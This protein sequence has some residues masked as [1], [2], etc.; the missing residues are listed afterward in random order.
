MPEDHLVGSPVRI[1]VSVDKEKEWLRDLF[2]G[3]IRWN[4]VLRNPN[5]DYTDGK[6]K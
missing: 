2:N 6:W 5:P 1:L 4:R 3:K